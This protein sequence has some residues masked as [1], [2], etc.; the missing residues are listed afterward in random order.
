MDHHIWMMELGYGCENGP[1]EGIF[2]YPKF[3]LQTEM[4]QL[5]ICDTFGMTGMNTYGPNKRSKQASRLLY[6]V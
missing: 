2:L 4:E 1:E 5:R 6:R 3:G